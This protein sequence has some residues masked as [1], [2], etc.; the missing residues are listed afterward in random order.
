MNMK[1]NQILRYLRFSS[2]LR[3]KL[4]ATISQSLI[5]RI[6]FYHNIPQNSLKET[7]AILN[8]LLRTTEQKTL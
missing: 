8:F 5:S 3:R 1:E 6:A 2:F 4:F 7:H